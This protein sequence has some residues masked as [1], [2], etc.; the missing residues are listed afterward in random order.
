MTLIF[1]KASRA[2]LVAIL[3]LLVLNVWLFWPGHLYFLNDDLLHIPLTDRGQ[4]FQTNSVRPVHEL[5]VK[6]DLLVYGK[7]AYGYHITA[8]LLHVVVCLQLFNLAIVIQARWLN[9]SNAEGL[10]AAFIAAVLFLLYPQHAESLAWISGRGAILST[11]FFLVS[12]RIFFVSRYTLLA[13]FIG[14]VSFAASLFSYEQCILFPVVLLWAA[15]L[16]KDHVVRRKQIMYVLLL[17]GTCVAYLIVRKLITHEIVGF[18]EGGNFLS[19]NLSNLAG[20][21]FRFL[22]RLFISP[23]SSASTFIIKAAILLLLASS[24][25]LL[26]RNEMHLNRKAVKFFGASIASLIIPVLSLGIS[27]HSFESGRYLY[28]PSVFLTMAMGIA[29]VSV[30]NNV[31]SS[32]RVVIALFVFVAVSWLS[33]KFTASRNYKEASAYAKHTNEKVVSHFNV[34]ADTLHIDTLYLNIHRLPVYRLGF[35]TGIKWLNNTIDTNKIVVDHTIDN[36]E[37]ERRK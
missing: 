23:S 8:L 33:G 34:S 36:M 7:Q 19:M 1:D 35:E 37:A 5:L 29:A 16:T 12:V 28:M 15:S 17:V 10:K 21:F 3:V 14:V 11:I 2:W 27:V 4:F 25:L 30:Y 31:K 32:R 24:I 18:Y 6:L 26:W 20:N 9:I 13:C 22:S